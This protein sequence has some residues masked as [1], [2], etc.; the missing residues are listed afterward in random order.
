MAKNY[1]VEKQCCR[2]FCC[3]SLI[4]CLHKSL[5]AANQ[6][7]IHYAETRYWAFWGGRAVEIVTKYLELLWRILQSTSTV[8]WLGVTDFRRTSVLQTLS[9][10]VS[11]WASMTLTASIIYVVHMIRTQFC[12][13]STM[14]ERRDILTIITSTY[15]C[16]RPLISPDDRI[17]DIL[18]ISSISLQ[19]WH[20]ADVSFT[21]APPIFLLK[22]HESLCY[23]SSK[24][25]SILLR[26]ANGARKET[27]QYTMA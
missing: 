5:S 9:V 14:N 27:N 16:W 15:T 24:A 18:G 12:L 7:L 8:H 3:A 13:S 1:F 17:L 21:S 25:T 20:T 26:Q 4:L 22:I 19:V 2:R 10:I 11:Y 6:P 23:P